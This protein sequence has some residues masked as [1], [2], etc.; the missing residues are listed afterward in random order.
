MEV[1]QWQVEIKVQT[2]KN[3]TWEHIFTAVALY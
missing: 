3:I 1:D 2:V